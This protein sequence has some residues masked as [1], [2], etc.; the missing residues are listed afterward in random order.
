MANQP[1]IQQL[2]CK[3]LNLSCKEVLQLIYQKEIFINNQTAKVN[4]VVAVTDSVTYRKQFIQLPETYRYFKFYKPRG[5]ECT[6]NSSIPNS[7]NQ[8]T[9]LPKGFS[10]AGRLDKESE[11]LLIFTNNGKWINETTKKNNQTEKIYLVT[12]NKSITDYFVSCMQSG[13]KILGKIT[14]PC[15]VEKI[16]ENQF[17]IILKQ[18]IN[19]QI[20]RMCYQLGYEVTKLTRI[21]FG[22]IKIDNLLLGNMEEIILFF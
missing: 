6:F 19:R 5:V 18:G 7:L 12:V 1:R 4:D 13:V 17:K 15:V 3:K 22:E 20:R 16:T 14:D 21:Q 8:L 9:N 11:G 10:Y 2:L